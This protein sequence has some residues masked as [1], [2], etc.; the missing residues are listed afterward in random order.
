LPVDADVR[1]N[2]RHVLRQMRAA[3]EQGADVGHFP[4]ACLSGYAGTDFQSYDGF[5]WD[6]LEVC[7]RQVLELAR[8]L[9]LWVVLGSTHRLTGRHKPHDSVYV[10]NDRGLIIDRYDKMFCSGDRSGRAYDLAHYSPGT[11]FSV[12]TMK[13]VRCG[14]LICYD[15]AFPE[16]YREYKRRGVQLMFHSYHVGHASP[17]RVE[18]FR[19][20]VGTRFVR[21]NRGSSFPEI[22]MP[23]AMHSAAA[24]NHMWI[25]CSNTSARQS[26][27]PSFFVR[28]DGIVTGRLRRNRPAVLISKVD[29]HE[30]LYDWTADWRPRAMRGVFHTGVPVRDKRSDNRTGL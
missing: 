27:F 6:L 11:H 8:A 25:S 14:V 21:L 4:E 19:R 17:S 28:A 20:E 26:C 5:D 10:I 22:M 18:F 23:A 13:G 2:T 30:R 12:F 16:L 9:R 15:Y 24:C 29:T 1:R 7:T 3:K